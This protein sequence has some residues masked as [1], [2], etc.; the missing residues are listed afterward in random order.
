[1]EIGAIPRLATRCAI[2]SQKDYCERKEMEECAYFIPEQIITAEMTMDVQQQLMQPLLRDPVKEDRARE[3]E[4][5]LYS[6]LYSNLT[7]GA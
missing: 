3:I 4:K 6:Q 2:C 7:F 1:M 5:T